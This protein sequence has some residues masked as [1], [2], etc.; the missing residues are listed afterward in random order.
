MIY[1]VL[2]LLQL[3]L[4]GDLVTSP[5]AHFVTSL[6]PAF[7]LSC[8]ND[9]LLTH[10]HCEITSFSCINVSLS[11]SSFLSWHRLSS[12]H[13]SDLIL[14]CI[15]FPLLSFPT[16]ISSSVLLTGSPFTEFHGYGHCTINDQFR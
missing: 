6:L 10:Y 16:P 9:G 15:A 12:F 11:F 13:G 8:V 14:T 2:I 5:H 3:P 1:I 7:S 4:W